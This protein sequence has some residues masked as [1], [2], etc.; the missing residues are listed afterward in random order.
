MGPRSLETFNQALFMKLGWGLINKPDALWVKVLRK[1]YRCGEETITVMKKNA[2]SSAIWRGIH[3][4][5]NYTLKGV[6]WILGNGK[7]TAGLV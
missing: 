3:N 6:T 2:K 1:K 7:K 5:W 4:T